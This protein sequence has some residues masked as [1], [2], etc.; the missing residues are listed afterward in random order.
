MLDL[1]TRRRRPGRRGHACTCSA[2]AAADGVGAVLARAVVLATGGMG[3]VFA[4]TTNP[5]VSTGDGVALAL[6]AG[7]V[8]T[9]LEFVQFHPTAL[10]LGAGARGQQPLVSE[11]L[12]GEG[13]LPGRRR[14][15]AV[16]GRASTS[17]P[18]WRPRDVVAKAI[19]RVMLAE[20]ADHVWLDARHSAGSCW[21][22]GSRP[23]SPAAGRPA[24][25]RSPS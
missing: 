15:Q 23:S 4:A 22:A 17:W 3:Q 18:T 16:H 21:S 14:R 7:A 6:R 12:R 1:L 25:T 20:G 19:Q 13:A 8:V 11:A 10:W 24:S 9:D 5:A 2:R